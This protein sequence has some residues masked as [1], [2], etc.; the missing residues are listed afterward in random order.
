M[1]MI[2]VYAGTE[3]ERSL[4]RP[5]YC[6]GTL[7]WPESDQMEKYCAEYLPQHLADYDVLISLKPLITA[8]SL[9]GIDRL[10]AIGRKEK[11][12]WEYR[13]LL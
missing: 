9:R 1:A 3:P 2:W 5:A 7:V 4:V 6:D 13:R 12:H 11:G 8:D 10:C